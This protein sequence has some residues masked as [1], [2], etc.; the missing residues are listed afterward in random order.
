M[1]QEHEDASGGGRRSL[2]DDLEVTR[3]GLGA[4]RLP[5]PGVWGPPVDHEEAVRLLRTALD[6][7]VT[8]IDTSDAYG[9]HVCNDLIREA[10]HPYRPELVIATKIG[11]IRDQSQAFV[12][13]DTPQQ[14]LEQ[15]EGN[16]RR[17][18][19]TYAGSAWT[20][21]IWSTCGWAEMVSYHSAP[22]HSLN[23]SVRYLTC[24]PRA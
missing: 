5:G 13:A 8:H 16:L 20:S 10:L 24:G 6:L 7:G 15:A 2:G 19:A 1:S 21:L 17:Q 3:P 14:L 4:M 9:P 11:V 18:K 12:A 23:R 22:H